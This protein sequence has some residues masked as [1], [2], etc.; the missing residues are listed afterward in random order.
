[1]P[2]PIFNGAS[3]AVPRGRTSSAGPQQGVNGHLFF[4]VVVE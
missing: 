4:V 2:R 1:M 3:G